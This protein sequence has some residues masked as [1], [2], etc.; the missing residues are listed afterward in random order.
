MIWK[1]GEAL[2]ASSSMGIAKWQ[3]TKRERE[4]EEDVAYYTKMVMG[5]RS[6]FT[7]QATTVIPLSINILS[8]LIN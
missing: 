2:K 6:V 5:I 4:R 7:F 1:E 3:P 8:L